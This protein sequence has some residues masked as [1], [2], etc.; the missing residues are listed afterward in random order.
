MKSITLY[1]GKT[2]V[3]SN[4]IGCD[5]YNGE[6]DMSE[7]IIF[8]N[9]LFRVIQD[10][11]TPIPGF[12]V[13]SSKRHIRTLNELNSEEQQNLCDLIIRTRKGMK[14]VLGID[15]VSLLQE[16]GS[17]N[18]HFHPW[19]FPWYSWMDSLNIIGSDTEKIRKIMKY[20]QENL[21]TTENIQ[22]IHDVIALMR[23]AY[24]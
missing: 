3:I 12:I 18:S 23:S 4:C 10:T 2:C 1:N 13:I 15:K 11:E 24:L 19:F 8:E 5:V 16:D 20:S 14:D 22:K 6:I 9:S 7:S 17:E 21:R